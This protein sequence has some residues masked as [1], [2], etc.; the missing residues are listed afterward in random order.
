MLIEI[1]STSGRVLFVGEH[2]NLRETVEAA[3]RS[4]ANLSGAD[5]SWA[6]LSRADLSRAYLSRIAGDISNSHE[7]L[8]AVAIRHDRLLSPV[9]AMIAGRYVGCWNEY[10]KA[11]RQYFGEA[12]MRQLWGAWSQDESWGVV[13]KMRE[14]GWPEPEAAEAAAKGE[15]T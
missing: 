15:A 14:H 8:A 1:T 6:D 13:A 7:L 3:V 10:T 12:T 4:K 11:I 2:E 9:A 5:L